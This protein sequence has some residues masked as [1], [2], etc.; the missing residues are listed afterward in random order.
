M[1]LKS[2]Q[3]AI[4]F[5]S[6]SKKEFSSSVFVHRKKGGRLTAAVALQN[7]KES[8]TFSHSEEQSRMTFTIFCLQN[9]L[10]EGKLILCGSH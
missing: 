3:K 9:I 2:S 6:Q 1:I 10:S 7:K 5:Y 4:N 8:K